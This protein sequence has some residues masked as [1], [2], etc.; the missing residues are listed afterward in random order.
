MLDLMCDDILREILG[1]FMGEN[2]VQIFIG[3]L[4]NVNKTFLRITRDRKIWEK[5][6]Y[7]TFPKETITKGSVHLEEYTSCRHGEY[8]YHP[9][10]PLHPI[11]IE[12][13][14]PRHYSNLK[15]RKK[16]SRFKDMFYQSMKRYYTINKNKNK[17]NI[18]KSCLIIDYISKIQELENKVEK[19]RRERKGAKFFEEKMSWFVEQEQK[20]KE[21]KQRNKEEND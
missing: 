6:Y 7:N 4:G 16:T 14:N 13:T 19:L 10:D 3:T 8:K 1:F 2:E 5:Y 11:I 17:W 9:W 15:I 18:N 21:E 20:K 12:C